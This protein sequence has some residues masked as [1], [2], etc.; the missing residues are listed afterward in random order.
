MIIPVYKP[1]GASTHLL[2]KKAGDIYQTKATHTGTLDPMADGV[3]V[4]LTAEDRFKKSELTDWKKT[5]EFEILWGISTDTHDLLGLTTKIGQK[6]INVKELEK[7]LPKFTGAIS[8]Q[9]PKFSAQRISGES[10]FDQ[11][12]K[13]IAFIPRSENIQIHSLELKNS[14]AI[15]KLQLQNYIKSRVNLVKGNFRQPQILAKWQQAIPHLSEKLIVTKLITTTSKKAYIRSLVR[16]I[17]KELSIPATTYSLTR[18]ANGDYLI[19]DCICL[20]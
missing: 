11:A 20:I 18:T 16:D 9:L 10:Y 17:S 6:Q 1:V 5:Y 8:Q 19:K 2:A 3:V 13:Q 15:N 12:K 7:I 4:V 14:Y